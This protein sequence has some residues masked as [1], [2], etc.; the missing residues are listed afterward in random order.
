MAKRENIIDGSKANTSTGGLIYTRKCGWID[1]GHAQPSGA[2]RLY[3]KVCDNTQKKS[4][5]ERLKYLQN[6]DDER[7]NTYVNPIAGREP[8]PTFNKLSFTS[9]LQNNLDKI[10]KQLGEEYYVVPYKQQMNCYADQLYRK[11]PHLWLGSKSFRGMFA[12]KKDLNDMQKKA[13]ALAIF[14]KV[15]LGFESMQQRFEFVTD[16]GF[17]AEDLVSNL[18]GFY[19]AINQGINYIPLCEPVSQKEA[20]YVWDTYGAVGLNK[21]HVFRPYLFPT[22]KDDKLTKHLGFLPEFLTEIKPA[23]EGELFVT[24]TTWG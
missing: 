6:K 18:L 15:S 21:N 4:T 8:L 3:E 14:M 5:E 17:S 12:I 9:S 20:L 1:L 13:V 11:L 7:R 10:K 2:R 22:S 24:I 23:I 19:R 16:S